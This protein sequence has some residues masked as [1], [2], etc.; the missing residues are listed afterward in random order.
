MDYDKLKL[1][2]KASADWAAG[3]NLEEAV[4]TMYGTT[5]PEFIKRIL[6]VRSKQ[7]AALKKRQAASRA[8]KRKSGKSIDVEGLGKLKHDGDAFVVR[9]K[10]LLYPKSTIDVRVEPE[11]AT[12]DAVGKLWG[13]FCQREKSLV[14]ELESSIA[15]YYRKIRERPGA[16]GIEPMPLLKRNADVWKTLGEPEITFCKRGRQVEMFVSWNPE[17]EEEHGLY[18]YLSRDAKI[19]HVGERE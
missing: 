17:W 11:V 15:K 2:T 10:T 1:L 3:R 8:K 19:R 4:K 18:V 14:R 16:G 6:E 9:K 13:K 5:D 12:S 7:T